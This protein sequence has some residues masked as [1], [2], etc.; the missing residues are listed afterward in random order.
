VFFGAGAGALTRW[1][2]ALT[3][4]AKHGIA[5]GTLAANWVGAYAIG[6]LV[7]Y[8]AQHPELSPMWRLVSITG[9]LGGLTTFSTFSA[10]SFSLLQAGEVVLALQHAALHLAG[11]VAL[12]WLGVLSFTHVFSTR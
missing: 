8:F 9:F 6:V 3:L 2:L 4:P 5:S 10:E 12:T 7:A 1:V 11:S